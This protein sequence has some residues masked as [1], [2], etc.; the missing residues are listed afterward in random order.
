MKKFLPIAVLCLPACTLF[1]GRSEADLRQMNEHRVRCQ[2]YFNARKFEKAI[3]QAERGL[4]IDP[5]DYG[6]RSRLGWSYLELASRT[7]AN[8]IENTN[9]SMS[10]RG[11]PWS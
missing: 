7:K 9:G 8:N 10:S 11:H 2:K 5:T 1:G 6:L 3:D 4:A